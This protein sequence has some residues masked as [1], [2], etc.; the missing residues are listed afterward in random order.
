MPFIRVDVEAFDEMME[1]VG[2]ELPPEMAAQRPS[3][4][5]E[6]QSAEATF[7]PA[8][9][10]PTTRLVYD[11]LVAKG[12]TSFRVSYDGGYDEGFAHAQSFEIN[13]RTVAADDMAEQI[14]DS[15]LV[16]QV[17]ALAEKQQYN[18]FQNEPDDLAAKYTLDELAHVLASQLLGDGYGTGEYEL[19]GAFT[20]N[21]ASHAI[22]DDPKATKPDSE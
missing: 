1:E 21:F 17:R 12:V 9:F 16:K 15:G 2:D 20:A 5:F 22:V 13:G 4:E 3:G 14:G 6:Y 18:P 7:D 8:E 11:A 19:Y 10:E